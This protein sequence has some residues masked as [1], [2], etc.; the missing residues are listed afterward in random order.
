S[1][2]GILSEGAEI[3][4]LRDAL[5]ENCRQPMNAESTFESCYRTQTVTMDALEHLQRVLSRQSVDN[6]YLDGYL[7]LV[8]KEAVLKRDVKGMDGAITW[9]LSLLAKRLSQ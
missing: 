4:S 1:E 6:D 5:H 3:L 2:G 9:G 8:A 7:E